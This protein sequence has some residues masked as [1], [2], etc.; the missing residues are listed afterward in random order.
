M[1]MRQEYLKKIKDIYD[2]IQELRKKQREYKKKGL[3]LLEQSKI[4]YCQ[5]I[6][7]LYERLVELSEEA[8]RFGRI[9]Y[10]EMAELLGMSRVQFSYH[11][12]FYYKRRFKK[13]KRRRRKMLKEQKS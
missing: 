1:T 5:K 6:P 12:N 8:H 4:I 10:K 3:E 2:K 13:L 11:I 9:P 7:Q